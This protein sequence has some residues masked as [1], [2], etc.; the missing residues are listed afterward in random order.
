MAIVRYFVDDVEK[1]VEFYTKVLGFKVNFSYKVFVEI[2]KEDLTIWISGPETSAARPMSDG[3]KPIP[4]G[5]NRIVLQVESMDDTVKM[6]KSHR[7]VFRNEPFT[8]V[9]GKQLLIED[10]SGNKIEISEPK[11]RS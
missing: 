2:A 5:W 8:G 11:Q 3:E 10:P 4:G 7:T 6:L 9:G 1:C